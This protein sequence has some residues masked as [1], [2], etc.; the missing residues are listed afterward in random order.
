MTEVRNFIFQVDEQ[1]TFLPVVH[2]SG[3]FA[4]RVRQELLHQ[5]YDCIAVPLPPSFRDEVIQAVDL[6]PIIHVVS[7][8]SR[9]RIPELCPRRTLSAGQHGNVLPQEYTSH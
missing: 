2:G 5:H 3:D 1:V 8:L 4:L 6:L 9:R 7:C